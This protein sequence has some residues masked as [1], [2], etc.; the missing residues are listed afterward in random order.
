MMHA[1]HL[2]LVHSFV[3]TDIIFTVYCCWC[4]TL[5]ASNCWKT[6]CVLLW[7]RIDMLVVFEDCDWDTA[8]ETLTES[9]WQIKGKHVKLCFQVLDYCCVCAKKKKSCMQA[10]CGSWGSWVKAVKSS[11]HCLEWR[12][13]WFDME[14]ENLGVATDLTNPLFI[15]ASG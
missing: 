12:Q 5:K 6:R 15:S 8:S 9:I 7:G 3:F 2:A 10:V 1:C 13:R 4:F 14:K 11:W